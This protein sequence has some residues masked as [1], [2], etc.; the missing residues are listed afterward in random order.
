[1]KKL[2]A[3]F[4][5]L[6]CLSVSA[7]AQKTEKFDIVSYTAPAGWQK[8]ATVDRVTFTM[9]DKDKGA[10]CSIALLRS[11]PAGDDTGKNFKVVWDSLAAEAF[12]V[13]SAPQMST[14]KRE[15]GWT[16][17]TGVAPFEKDGVKAVVMLINASGGGRMVNIL[18]LTNT[19]AYQS[20]IVSFMDSLNL[21]PVSVEKVPPQV[22]DNPSSGIAS[23]ISKTV[24]TTTDGW[25]ARLQPDYVLGTKGNL[26]IFLMFTTRVNNFGGSE[27]VDYFWKKD[28]QNM[29]KVTSTEIH[30]TRPYISLGYG[31]GN[32]V[33]KTTGKS[34][35]IMMTV[36]INNATYTPVIA[37]A[38]DKET[39]YAAFPTAN[40]L[41][42]MT[43]LNRFPVTA[44]DMIGNWDGSASPFVPLVNA[45]TGA[46]AGMN[47]AATS[48][49]FTFKSNGTYDSKHAGASSI[50]GSKSYYSGKFTGK[51][52]VK[53]WEITL[54]NRENG[55]TK[56]YN[57][58][59]E[60]VKGGRI[61]H[62]LSGDSYHLFQ[63]K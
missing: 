16:V 7:S 14:P 34:V 50:Y 20:K 17:E 49:K 53:D 29:F 10:F 2:I 6:C 54:T 51:F 12:K 19:D 4:L 61:L 11:L 38:P 40:A 27:E 1:M 8:S 28:V 35:Y 59:F 33:D 47:M 41:S 3:L 57:S 58:Y 46:S 22:P 55:K 44:T 13:T 43:G 39:L 45:T 42:T 21:P 36:L 30:Q 15:K 32:A 23:G 25:T 9:E 48:D 18:V 26:S 56:V 24:V 37:V 62:M 60:A 52:T 63:V 5:M 31:E